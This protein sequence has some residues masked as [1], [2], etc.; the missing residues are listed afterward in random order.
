MR[1]NLL[2]RRLH[3]WGAVVIGLPVVLVISTGLLLQVKKQV[4]W[5]QPAEQRTDATEPAVQWGYVLAAARGIP[6]AGVRSWS[7]IDREDVRPSKGILKVG[8]TA[9]WELQLR[10]DDGTVLQ[11][12][13]R[14]SDLI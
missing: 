7:D 13:Y 9:R 14:R 2:T 4:P 5:V 8:T 10:I 3:R 11:T 6:E 12:E 1:L